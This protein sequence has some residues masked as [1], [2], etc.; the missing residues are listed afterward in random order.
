MAWLHDERGRIKGR[1]LTLFFF[2]AMFQAASKR[3]HADKWVL[4]DKGV[5]ALH[6]LHYSDKV[7][8]P[9]ACLGA[10]HRPIY[11]NHLAKLDIKNCRLMPAD[12]KF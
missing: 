6:K 2:P 5:S 4:R 10:S 9:I 3:F 11:T 8:S 1:A 7:I 12:F